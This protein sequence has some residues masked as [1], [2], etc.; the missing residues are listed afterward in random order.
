MRLDA[1]CLIYALS[2][3]AHGSSNPYRVFWLQIQLSL[4]QPEAS[5]IVVAR[6]DSGV[7]VGAF[8]SMVCM[9]GLLDGITGA[10]VIFRQ[11]SL[12]TGRHI[13]GTGTNHMLL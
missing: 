13:Y 7:K 12:G 5:A 9:P 1:P 8:S 10:V 11:A 3:R 4:A 2:R 6:L